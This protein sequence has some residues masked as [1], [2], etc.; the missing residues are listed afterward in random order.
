MRNIRTAL[1]TATLLAVGSGLAS[2]Q[3]ATAPAAAPTAAAPASKEGGPFAAC[4]PALDTLCANVEKGGG[5]KIK[6]LKENESKLTA[7]CKTAL[8]A[9]MA[10]HA[11]RKAEKAA[12]A[13]APAAPA[14]AP[15]P[16]K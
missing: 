3:Q 6:C 2:A 8:D 5:R 9:A 1:L 13:P 16:Q 4:K 12:T 11:Q 10:A 7:E 14:P 15:A